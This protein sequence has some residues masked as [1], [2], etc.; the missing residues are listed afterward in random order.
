MSRGRRDLINNKPKKHHY[1]PVFYL[2]RW[3]GPDGRLCE[4]SRPY[5]HVVKPRMTHPAGTAYQE[6]LYSLRGFEPHLAQQIEERFFHFTDSLAAEAL[7]RL[8]TKGVA[9]E[10]PGELRSA[11]SRFIISL[12]LRTP[13]DIEA[14]RAQ[15]KHTFADAS[16]EGEQEYSKNRRETD[17]PTFSEYLA[18]MPLATVEGYLFQTY[19]PI[20]D[21][22]RVGATINQMQWAIAD[23]RDAKFELLTSDRPVIRTGLNYQF[24]HIALPIGPHQLF[25]AFRNDETF[26]R[27]KQI[28]VNQLVA[29]INARVVSHATHLVFGRSD[30]Q[31]RFVSNRLG[32]APSPVI[33]R[34]RSNPGHLDQVD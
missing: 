6:N 20:V 24:A 4:F 2:R 13:P 28:P 3:A 8:V 31:L 11:W 25:A 18:T 19:L 17:P 27:F 30:S 29:D 9:G 10:W 12:L 21:N 26:A 23:T 32:S 15:W 22:Q 14:L 7:D 34:P 5:G 16:E 1:I 33:L